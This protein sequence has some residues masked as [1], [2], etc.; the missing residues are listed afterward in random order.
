MFTPGTWMAGD[1]SVFR[2]SCRPSDV[3]LSMRCL[4]HLYIVELLVRVHLFRRYG[5]AADI[6]S[7]NLQ[8]IYVL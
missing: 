3:G 8:G 7:P 4:V 1:P 5:P 2:T 6:L